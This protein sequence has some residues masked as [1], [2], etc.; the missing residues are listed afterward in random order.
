MIIGFIGYFAYNQI[1]N[2]Y[3]KELVT[4][5]SQE[6]KEFEESDGPNRS[7]RMN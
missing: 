4:A 5:I 3:K 2:W 1:I 6:R 7:D